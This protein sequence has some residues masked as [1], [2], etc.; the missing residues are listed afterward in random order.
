MQ[1]LSKTD[2]RLLG[3]DVPHSN[4]SSTGVYIYDPSTAEG[5]EVSF[6]DILDHI[7]RCL[8]TSPIF[9]RKLA[10]VPLDLD[11]PYWV[12]DEYF[13]LEDHVRHV[14]LPKPGTWQQFCTLAARI[15]SRPLDLSRPLWEMYVVEG[16]D[17]IEG[18]PEGSFGIL[19]K[20]HHAAIGRGPDAEIM[21]GLHDSSSRSEM[22]VPGLICVPEETPDPIELL[23]RTSCKY[24]ISPLR[25]FRPVSK[26]ISQ[27]TPSALKF[28]GG[29]LIHPKGIPLTRFN[30]E[31]TSRRVWESRNYDLSDIRA[32]TRAVPGATVHDVV[33]AIC[34]GALARYLLSKQELPEQGLIGLIPVAQD[35]QGQERSGS[36]TMSFFRQSL[37]TEI[38]DPLERLD[39]ISREAA[40]EG[41]MDGAINAR[42]LMDINQYAQS[43][44]LALASR[45]LTIRLAKTAGTPQRVH[46]CI[47]T[48][49]GTQ[50]PL[51]LKGAKMV[52]TSGLA[53]LSEGLG[54]VIIANSYNG[55]LYISPTSCREILPEPAEFGQCLEES[56]EDLKVAASRPRGKRKRDW[57]EVTER[58]RKVEREDDDSNDEGGVHKE[59]NLLHT[60][61]EVRAALELAAVPLSLPLLRSLPRG[62][63]H[64]VMVLPGFSADDSTTKVL[65]YFLRKQGY[66]VQSWG[67][68]RNT[69]LAGN[70]EERVAER[71][72]KLAKRSG[73]KVSLVGH[74]LGGLIARHVAHDLPDCVRQVITIGSPNGIDTKASNITSLISKLYG[75]VNP[76]VVLRDSGLQL[77][78]ARLERWR[79]SPA[80]PLTAIYSRTDGIVHW[81]SCLDPEEHEFSENVRV[82]ASHVGIVHHPMALWVIADRLA[83]LEGEWQPFQKQGTYGLWH[84]FM[85]PFKLL[86]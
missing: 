17:R 51:Y 8:H 80:V 73:R 24:A 45:A 14:A 23:L 6:D 67:F 7:E 79:H 41:S 18:F 69:G 1:Q 78:P 59:P 29:Q 4:V 11:R 19:T 74:S 84:A 13:E 58:A 52:Y 48:V 40:N 60:L 25:M 63:E 26:L 68:S 42:V 10:Q 27:A 50:D 33:L 28:Y 57:F 56:F 20:V 71:V 3:G 16:L 81:T 70:I 85:S 15:H 53:P 76:E 66:A 12:V 43:E 30:R 82:P 86:G 46:C 32:I 39:A 44:S 9:C 83:Q 61:L 21:A 55:R 62:D 49:P 54:L 36:V 72:R 2:S 31:V 37:H 75:A 5:G 65:R 34:G 47:T 77:T 38:A 22:S 64:P 35:K